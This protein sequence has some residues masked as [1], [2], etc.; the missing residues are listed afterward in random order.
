[1]DLTDIQREAHA[2]ASD[3]GWFAQGR[4]FG[5]CNASLHGSLSEAMGAYLERGLE[6]WIATPA[7][8]VA[9]GVI[10]GDGWWTRTHCK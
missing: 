10:V 2:I 3:H 7:A 6:A 8:H 1:M 5:D 4:T 9:H